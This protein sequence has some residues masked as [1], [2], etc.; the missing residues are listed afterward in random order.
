MAS[1][2]IKGTSMRGHIRRQEGLQGGGFFLLLF[3]VFFEF[4]PSSYAQE[5]TTS[6]TWR[7]ALG[8]KIIGEP[9]SQASS[10]V[11]LCDDGTVRCF[12]HTGKPLWTFDSHS[13]LLP[14]VSRAPDGS[15]YVMSQERFLIALNRAGR[16]LWSIPL[17]APLQGP[18]QF[19][20]DGRLFIP[21]P[22]RV[23]CFTAG[24]FQ[25]WER[26][27]PFPLRGELVP[28]SQGGVLGMTEGATLIRLSA[29][30]KVEQYSCDSSPCLVFSL[31]PEKQDS[32]RGGVYYHNG[33]GEIIGGGKRVGPLPALSAPPIHAKEQQGKLA[34]FLENGK[35]VLFNL[36]THTLLWEGAVPFY[37]RETGRKEGAS[38]GIAGTESR[39]LFDERGVYYLSRTGAVGFTPTGQRLWQ[40]TL[41][42]ASS[43]PAFSDEGILYA[44]GTDWILYAYKIEERVRSRTF[45]LYG[46]FPEGSYG[47]AVPSRGTHFMYPFDTEEAMLQ[48]KL[49]EIQEAIQNTSIG[50]KE[51]DY[52]EILCFIAEGTVPAGWQPISLFYRL[53]ALTML[54]TFGSRELIPFLANLVQKETESLVIAQA[55]TAIATIG[56]DP[57]G[58]AMGAFRYLLSR[59]FLYRNEQ[60][61]SSLANAIY[62]LC[63]FSGP[64]LSVEG[65]HLLVQLS[66]QSFSVGFQNT[67]KTYLADLRKES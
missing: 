66:N 16:K 61:A 5:F 47:F 22:D 51:R 29:Q 44:G 60:L 2:I 62:K 59:P 1:T 14:F 50:E 65:I 54:G 20:W 12:S 25:L 46:P 10:V 64:P 18:I 53:Q 6:P 56:S 67:I 23:L 52:Y 17:A 24:G 19:G 26:K 15:T 48:A 30:G 11:I 38:S 57:F 32:W 13:K 49:K 21:L 55:L 35:V 28:D 63:L 37:Q 33:T 9:T 41:K 4:L 3:F 31:P 27:L 58:Y 8:A 45:S 36:E 40:L 39:L 34:L 42:G 43:L 7:E